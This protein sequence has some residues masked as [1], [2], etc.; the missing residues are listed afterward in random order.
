MLPSTTIGERLLALGL[1]VG[2]DE[3]LPFPSPPLAAPPSVLPSHPSPLASDSAESKVALDPSRDG[4]AT[5]VGLAF[6]LEAGRFGQ[7]TYMRVY[8]G[9]VARGDFIVN[10]RSGKKVKVSRLVQ[11][12]ADKMQV[13]EMQ[14]GEMEVGEMEVGEMEVGE[15]QVGEMQVGEMQV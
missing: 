9:R 12:H 10:T 8:Q 1:S 15:M 3:A 13:G 11:M 5:F 6:K 7:L 14:V 2:V 4:S